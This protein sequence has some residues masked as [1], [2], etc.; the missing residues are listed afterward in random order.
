MVQY[1][2]GRYAFVVYGLVATVNFCASK[3]MKI[4]L[5]NDESDDSVLKET[6]CQRCKKDGKIICHTI[7]AK[8]IYRFYLFWLLMGTTPSFGA[9]DYLMVK[10]VF[11]LTQVQYSWLY[12]T[13]TVTL[14]IGIFIYQAFFKKWEF[15]HL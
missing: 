1:W 11:K 4:S 12:V 7:K 5:E 2:E 3:S 15:R 8:A 13:S 14:L 6:F 10:Q 9:A